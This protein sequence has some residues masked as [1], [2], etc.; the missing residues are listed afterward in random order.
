MSVTVHY[1]IIP[2]ARSFVAEFPVLKFHPNPESTRL[3]LDP[4]I[5]IWAT[6]LSYDE[7][8]ELPIHCTRKFRCI[9]RPYAPLLGCSAL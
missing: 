1:H 4:S 2:G 5:R 8:L 7:P 6:C 9:P 3:S